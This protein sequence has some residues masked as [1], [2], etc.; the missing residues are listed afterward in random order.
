M[1]DKIIY[2]NSTSFTKKE[3][4]N[5]DDVNQDIVSIEIEGFANTNS[6]D[7]ADDVIPNTA[8][9][10]GLNEFNKNPILLAF[11]NHREP[12]GRVL[13]HEIRD[14]GLWVKARV[15]SAAGKVFN[16]V[17]DGIITAFSVG[18]IVKDAEYRPEADLFVIKELELLEISLVSVGMNSDALFSLSKSFDSDEDYK[19]FKMKFASEPSAKESD[20][21]GTTFIEGINMNEEE[22]KALLA[23]TAADAAAKVIEAQAEA[24][25]KAEE[26]AKAKAAADAAIDARIKEALSTVSVESNVDKILEAVTERLKAA[27]KPGGV[28]ESVDLTDLQEQLRAKDAQL[29]AL[30]K[31]KMSFSEKETQDVTYAEK[32]AAVLIA[33]ITKKGIGDTKFGKQLIEKVGPH[34]ASATWELEVSLRMEE[35]VRRR[36]VV[37]PTMRQI[38]MKTNVQTIPINPE[39][40][41]ATWVTNAQFGT[42]ASTGPAVVHQLGEVTLNAYKVATLEYVNFEEEEDSLLPLIP[43]IRDAMV[44]RLAKAI[45][46]AFLRGAGTG[47]DPVKGLA[48]WDAVSAVTN[49]VGTAV[50]VAKLQALR[51]D[52]GAWGLDPMDLRYIVSTDVYFELLEDTTFQTVDKIA[53]RA[54]LLTGQIGEIART[55][56]LV[57]DSFDTKTIGNDAAICFAPANFIVGNQ[58]GLRF[59]TD[60][61]V[62][63]QRQVLVASI[64]TG[65]TQLT[66]NLGAGV[67][68][69]EYVA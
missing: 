2:L 32:E 25:R 59:D 6:P 24:A 49:P 3:V 41:I 11:H 45:D 15:S 58:R 67:S 53:D 5:E 13:S 29:E 7:R 42:T 56:V 38:P 52:L 14:K 1:S 69:L 61:L 46:L 27:E 16:L 35:E 36:L 28:T 9:E 57:S 18:F 22:L 47:G 51:K 62:E 4:H 50:T 40:G 44:R 63:T 66:T 48:L 17:K 60:N 23:K 54:T 65:M 19:N 68:A 39:A 33:A 37:A 26:E 30:K 64:R 12:V 31:S 10:K 34:V 55:P 20:K 43:I 8:W 21:P